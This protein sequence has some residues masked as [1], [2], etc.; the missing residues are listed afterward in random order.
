MAN[1]RM[2]LAELPEAVNAY[3]QGKAQGER[4]WPLMELLQKQTPA[5]QTKFWKLADSLEDKYNSE[6]GTAPWY[7]VVYKAAN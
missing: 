4:M 5:Y 2:T 3:L 7:W 6:P 1:K